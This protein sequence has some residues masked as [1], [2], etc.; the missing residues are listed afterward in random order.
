CPGTWVGLGL[1][2][3]NRD[4]TLAG[5]AITVP[6][7]QATLAT[8]VSLVLFVLP[9]LTFFGSEWLLYQGFWTILLYVLYLWRRNLWVCMLFHGL[10]NAPILIPTV[11]SSA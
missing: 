6:P 8:T 2:N 3:T 11:L 1:H 4:T 10:T 9:H 5:P 7:L